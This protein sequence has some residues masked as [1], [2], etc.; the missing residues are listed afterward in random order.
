MTHTEFYEKWWHFQERGAGAELLEIAHPTALMYLDQEFTKYR[1]SLDNPD[2]F[3]W[4]QIK[5][6]YGSA[7]IYTSAP[8]RLESVWQDRVTEIIHQPNQL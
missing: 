1:D 6:K 7:R 2:M 4:S 3:I 8:S 5:M